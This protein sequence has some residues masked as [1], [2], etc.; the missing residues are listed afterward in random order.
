[1]PQLEQVSTYL[2]QVVWL[3]ITFSVLYLVLWKSALPRIAD[4]LQER[5]ERIDDDLQKAE[6][7][8][9][10]AEAVLVAYDATVARAR[11]EAQTVLR[12]SAAAFATEAAKRQDEIGS[13]LA[14]EATAAEARIDAAR[15][16]ALDNVR[17][18][19]VEV[20]QAATSRLVG[21]EVSGNDADGAV[22][23]TLKDRD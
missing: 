7:V 13:R 10:E 19:A 21:I 8:K 16:E 14:E 4:I 15:R 18:V 6:A 9:R 5:Q 17:T 20:A 1:M 22:A 11:E 23:D 3:V 12:E 2:S